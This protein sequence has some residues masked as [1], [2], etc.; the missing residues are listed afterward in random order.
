MNYIYIYK[1]TYDIL[2][3]IWHSYIYIYW[4]HDYMQYIAIHKISAPFWSRHL[5][6]VSWNLVQGSIERK[7]PDCLILF[8][9][10]GN[11]WILHKIFIWGW[12][13]T[14]YPCSSHQN[15]WDLWMFIPLKMVSIGIDP[16][17]YGNMMKYSWWFISVIWWTLPTKLTA[18][19]QQAESRLSSPRILERRR[20]M[21]KI[22]GSPEMARAFLRLSSPDKACFFFFGYPVFASWS[23]GF[24]R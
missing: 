4:Y 16:Y 24:R 8:A 13:K 18:S 21:S 3:M 19:V 7:K 2:Y 6:R 22:G 1:Y 23:W 5:H 10:F 12:V 15:S 14:L 20:S 17:P 11:L 9:I